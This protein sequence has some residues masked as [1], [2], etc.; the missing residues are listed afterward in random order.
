MENRQMPGSLFFWKFWQSTQ[1]LDNKRQA[2]SE[3]TG[4][5]AYRKLGRKTQETKKGISARACWRQRGQEVFEE[6]R[7]K[8]RAW[9]TTGLPI[10]RAPLN[11]QNS[12][13]VHGSPL[14]VAAE[15]ALG[16]RADGSAAAGVA[17]R[18]AALLQC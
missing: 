2:R 4:M 18:G 16:R 1:I 15:L 7:R 6:D 5:G 17:A 9:K 8:N 13:S 12:V 14:G 11:R 3:T 10:H